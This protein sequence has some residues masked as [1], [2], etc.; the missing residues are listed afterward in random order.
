[1]WMVDWETEFLFIW[2]NYILV[3]VINEQMPFP[4][5]N[6][7][8]LEYKNMQIDLRAYQ[9]KDEEAVIQLWKEFYIGMLNVR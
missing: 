5:E 8:S 4:D 2:P 1:M 9:P 7:V 3:V 6:S